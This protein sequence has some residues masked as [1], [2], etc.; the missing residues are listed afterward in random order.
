M[1]TI[2]GADERCKGFMDVMMDTDEANEWVLG[3]PTGASSSIRLESVDKASGWAEEE[4]KKGRPCVASLTMRVDGKE[5]LE[6]VK[7]KIEG[8][9]VVFDFRP[10]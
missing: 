8:D 9:W 7:E 1:L 10:S 5:G 2:R 6:G 4:V 3:T